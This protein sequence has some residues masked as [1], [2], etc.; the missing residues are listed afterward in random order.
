MNRKFRVAAVAAAFALGA[1]AAVERTPAKIV[2]APPKG[3]T[4]CSAGTSVTL[5]A[6]AKVSV[7]GTL[8]TRTPAVISYKGIHYATAKRWE[9]PLP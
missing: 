4:E 9:N 5:D 3:V 8:D 1:C 7:C 6:K 2:N